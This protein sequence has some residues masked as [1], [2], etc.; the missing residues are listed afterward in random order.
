MGTINFKSQ[1]KMN[2]KFIN[3]SL[4]IF[5]FLGIYACDERDEVFTKEQYK[6]VFALISGDNNVSEKYHTLGKESIGYVA[7]SCGGTN[8]IKEDIVINLV[9]DP[10]LINKYNTSNFDV[11]KD[12]YALSLPKKNYDIDSYSFSIPAGD[13]YG[14]LPIHIKP[15]GLSPD[16]TYFLSLRVESYSSYESNPDKNY[17][18]YR[19]KIE[20]YWADCD[21]VTY[22]MK[23]KITENGATI[24]VPGSRT[25]F[26]LGCD[27]LRLMVG[28]ETYE[29]N[30]AM[31][32]QK[33]I[34]LDID[35][36]TNKVTILPYR[37]V[38]VNQ[39]DGDSLYPNIFKIEDDGY[40]T[41]KTFLLCY[42]Y[43]INNVTRLIKEE[44][45]FK[46]DADDYK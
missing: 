18:L 25:L 17:I 38:K 11:D 32:N 42:E 39:I 10:S 22:S 46:F 2:M 13:S 3:I 28:N 4:M 31:L 12:K 20:N 27:S 23:S 30:I 34:V 41:Y 1:K 9:E 43:T 16:S 15:D 29:S 6:N 36:L 21:G 24:E 14:K 40:Y 8:V 26:P 5:F 19:V 7:A 37:T 33:A 45:R 44:L 35:T